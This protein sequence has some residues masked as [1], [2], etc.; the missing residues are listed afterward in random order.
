MW[1][2]T[3]YGLNRY[4]GYDFKV[5]VPD[6]RNPNSLSGVF[7]SALFKDRDG[8]LWVGCDRFLNKFESATEKFTH[9]QSRR[10]TTSVKI[11]PECC[12]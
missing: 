11:R 6:P 9:Y 10:S 12:G 8:T 3:Q 7:I 2:G 4:D 5:F 1:F